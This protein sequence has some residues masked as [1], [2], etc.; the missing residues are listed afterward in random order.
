[1][2]TTPACSHWSQ[3]AL[4]TLDIAD[5]AETG[6]SS[7]IS[8]VSLIGS[9]SDSAKREE[10]KLKKRVQNRVAQRKYRTY[11]A[12]PRI[13]IQCLESDHFLAQANE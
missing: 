3:P 12:P 8:E 2:R 9:F 10:K 4:G 5:N 1:M 11:Y 6:H 13:A 7:P